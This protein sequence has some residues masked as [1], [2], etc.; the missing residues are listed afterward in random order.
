MGAVARYGVPEYW[1]VDPVHEFIEVHRDLLD[2]HC[3]RGV[4]R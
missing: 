3:R 2:R 1:I 4:L